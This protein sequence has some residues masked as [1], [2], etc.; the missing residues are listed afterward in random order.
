MLLPSNKKETHSISNMSWSTS[1]KGWW[2]KVRGSNQQELAEQEV[3]KA[4]QN[5]ADVRDRVMGELDQL[6]REQ[7]MHRGELHNAMHSNAPKQVLMNLT[8]KLKA[9]E[10]AMQSKQQ[11]LDNVHR[12]TNQLQ[13]ANTNSQ[14]AAAYAQSV[15]AQHSLAKLNLGVK[16]DDVLDSVEM[17]REDTEELT[18]RLGTLGCDDIDDMEEFDANSVVSAMGM[19]TDYKEDLLL[20]ECRAMMSDQ[21]Q[22]SPPMGGMSRMNS[23]GGM[24]GSYI[25]NNMSMGA[26]LPGMRQRATHASAYTQNPGFDMPSVPGAQEANESEE[27]QA[28][29]EYA[30]PRTEY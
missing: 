26:T 8:K 24:G 28:C 9:I 6:Q 10:R 19:R 3:E 22:P 1:V 27:I 17:N 30:P 25:P 12:E 23:M 5:I 29:L 13:D 14:V 11:L 2:K 21:W 18:D 16:V 7:N 20:Q 15:E 4:R